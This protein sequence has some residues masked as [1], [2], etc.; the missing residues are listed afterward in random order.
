[1]STVFHELD[2]PRRPKVSANVT[3]L[4]GSPLRTLDGRLVSGLS[5]RDLEIEIMKR[6]I[7]GAPPLLADLQ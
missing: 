5:D 3:T 7:L 1:M 4:P 2:L 6:R